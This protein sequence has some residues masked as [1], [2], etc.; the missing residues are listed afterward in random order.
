MK[1]EQL[2]DKMEEHGVKLPLTGTGPGERIVARDL[3]HAL[4]SHF[5]KTKYEDD[6]IRR[7][8]CCIRRKITP[9]KAYRYN[10][11][12]QYD[13]DRL[14]TPDNSWIFEEKCN[15]WRMMI[16]YIPKDGFCFWGG[17]LSDVDFL[18][19]DYTDHI[20]LKF[21]LGDGKYCMLHPRHKYFHNLLN[22][23]VAIDAEAVCNA[24]VALQTGGFSNNTLEAVGAI[25]GSDPKRAQELQWGAVRESGLALEFKCFD[26][27]L[28]LLNEHL[29]IDF[30]SPLSVRQEQLAWALKEIDQPEM[31]QLRF[32]RKHK[33]AFL[34]KL[35]KE[36]NEGV[37]AKHRKQGYVPGGRLRDVAVKIKRTM[38]G[39]IGD[40]IDAYVTGAVSTPEWSKQGL[41]GGLQMAVQIPDDGE[42]KKEHA[43]AVI[44]AMPDHV[45]TM[46]TIADGQL[47]PAYLGKVLTIDGQELS[48]RNRKLMHA[49]A[50]WNRGFRA[51]KTYNDCFIAHLEG[52]VIEE[53]K[54]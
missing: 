5:L 8:H 31:K 53:E 7:L 29:H 45:R 28:P 12:A 9:M 44:T 18:P 21:E 32:I 37:V 43:I 3:E 22:V 47:D 51:D 36:G 42:G 10:K 20:L 54:F 27:L 26:M 6:P 52:A 48:S 50:D 2:I 16:T 46:L 17:N 35:W 38:S 13:K 40:D 41:I 49:K 15:G 24:T 1:L 14:F 25:L 19:V 34:I 30:R 23:S 33:R 11:L 39:E 4:G